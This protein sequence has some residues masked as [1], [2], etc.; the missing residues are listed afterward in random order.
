MIGSR[1]RCVRLDEAK[2]FGR[3][4]EHTDDHAGPFGTA[5]GFVLRQGELSFLDEPFDRRPKLGVIVVRDLEL[6]R[7]G[8]ERDRFVVG[9]RDQP[10]D[11]V[12]E[13]GHRE[14]LLDRESSR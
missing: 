9:L 3:P 10:G 11:A 8:L 7:Q 13:F 6:T 2:P 12:G 14:A 5:Q 1:R 4:P